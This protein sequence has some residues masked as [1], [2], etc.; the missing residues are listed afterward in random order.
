MKPLQIA[1]DIV[2]LAEFKAK[3]A[4]WLERVRESGQPV[5]ITQNGKPAA[6][7]ISPEE[8]DRFQQ[9]NREFVRSEIR[10]GENAI[11]EGRV[12]TTNEV[13]SHLELRRKIRKAR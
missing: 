13:K 5:I 7:M 3:S 8:Y 9:Q 6:V 12:Y 1:K 4:S 11:A 10:L 2:P